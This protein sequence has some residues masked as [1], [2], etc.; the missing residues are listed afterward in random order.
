MNSLHEKLNEVS[1]L[2][3]E[4]NAIANVLVDRW[5]EAEQPDM[6]AIGRLYALIRQLESATAA[7]VGCYPL[8]KAVLQEA[9]S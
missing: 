4:S 9:R 3:S 6:P 2:I 7:L 1:C 8:P 5:S